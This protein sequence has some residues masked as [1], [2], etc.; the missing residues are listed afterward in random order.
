MVEG[1]K[2]EEGFVRMMRRRLK[3]ERRAAGTDSDWPERG[4]GWLLG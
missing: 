2:E 3:K 1:A 4:S